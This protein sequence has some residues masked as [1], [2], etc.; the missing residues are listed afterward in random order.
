MGGRGNTGGRGTAFGVRRSAFRGPSTAASWTPTAAPAAPAPPLLPSRPMDASDWDAKYRDAE[1][2]WSAGPNRFLPPE[3]DG[4]PRGRAVDLACGEGRNALWLAEQGWTVRGVDWSGV[5]LDRARRLAA[6]RGVDVDWVHAD[7]DG[8]QLEP[9]GFD[10]VIVFYLQVPWDQMSAALDK[11][12]RAVAPGGHLV[13]VGHD[14]DNLAN[15]YGGPQYPEVLYTA[16]Q[17]ANA[18]RQELTVDAARRVD[19]PVDTPEGPKV[20]IDNLVHAHRPD[21]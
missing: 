21:G 20:A 1:L 7:L 10:L 4:L 6:E 8:Y 13:V 19:R 3:V 14:A 9:Q 16:D 15:G 2:L 17:V 18:V 5:A 11:A 12:A